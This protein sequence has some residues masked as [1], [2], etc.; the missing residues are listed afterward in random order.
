M[1][2]TT[3]PCKAIASG[4]VTQ[5]WNKGI[6]VGGQLLLGVSYQR[7]F[8]LAKMTD[9]SE[10]NSGTLLLERV[11]S[12]TASKGLKSFAS[13]PQTVAEH[14]TGMRSQKPGRS[15]NQSMLITHNLILT[16]SL[17]LV[18]PRPPEVRC[19]DG[20]FLGPKTTAQGV[21]KPRVY[22]GHFDRIVLTLH[23][24]AAF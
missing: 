14:L 13:F 11:S 6:V 19:L 3:C 21:W 22:A 9:W 24:M 12:K 23:K 1:D 5:W 16:K 10:L 7:T 18:C 15:L 4:P 2:T 17:P 8:F 20:M